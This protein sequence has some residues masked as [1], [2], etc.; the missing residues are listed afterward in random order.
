MFVVIIPEMRIYEGHWLNLQF[1]NLRQTSW[2]N[3]SLLDFFTG[4]YH[5]GKCISIPTGILSFKDVSLFYMYWWNFNLL[6]PHGIAPACGASDIRHKSTPNLRRP[7]YVKRNSIVLLPFTVINQ[8]MGLYRNAEFTYWALRTPKVNLSG[9][10]LKRATN[11]NFIMFQNYRNWVTVKSDSFAPS[12]S[13]L[14]NDRWRVFWFDKIVQIGSKP[15]CFKE[16]FI[17]RS[18]S[19]NILGQ[20][21]SLIDQIFLC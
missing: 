14:M 5:L 2:F 21:N 13:W 15:E 6:L 7:I 3:G 20:S 9:I 19:T 1:R 4:G 17:F 8:H 11:Q 18:F 16:I 10:S 12:S